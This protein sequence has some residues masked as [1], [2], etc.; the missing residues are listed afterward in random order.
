MKSDCRWLLI[1]GLLASS[2]AAQTRTGLEVKATTAK[3][4]YVDAQAGSN[5]VTFLSSSTL[6]DFTGVVNRVRGKCTLDPTHVEKLAGKFSIRVADM[7]TGIDLRDEHLRSADWLDAEKFPEVQI[8]VLSADEV[9]RTAAH[10]VSLTLVGQCTIK[11]VTKALRVP[12]TLTYLDESPET[13]RRAKGDLLR[14]RSDFKLKLSDYGVLG[15]QGTDIIGLK[16]SDQLELKCAIF[17]SSEP[18][19]ETLKP[20]ATPTS[21]PGVPPPPKRP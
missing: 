9:K 13:Q 17:A 6:E 11:G 18:P 19:P 7:R 10:T 16:V 14:L 2:A 8:E 1:A 20:D 21:K 3:T 15:P 12:A 5:Q 4:F